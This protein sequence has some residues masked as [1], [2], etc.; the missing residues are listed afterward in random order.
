LLSDKY[1]SPQNP[2]HLLKRNRVDTVGV[3]DEIS[4]KWNKFVESKRIYEE[5]LDNSKVSCQRSDLTS[6]K[7][8]KLYTSF[9]QE[10]T[11]L[12]SLKQMFITG[13][14][15]ETKSVEFKEAKRLPQHREA[16][17]KG[18][19]K[20][21]TMNKGASKGNIESNENMPGFSLGAKDSY[22]IHE[23]FEQINEDL[24]ARKDNKFIVFNGIAVD[25]WDESKPMTKLGGMIDL[26][27]M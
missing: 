20:V 17:E 1:S 6:E 11:Q 21:E 2:S 12:T 16:K 26:F 9:Y 15:E 22:R 19:K 3:K 5:V 13:N 25:Y 27:S 24:Y 10:D 7:S 4:K 23:G 14:N 8:M 18:R